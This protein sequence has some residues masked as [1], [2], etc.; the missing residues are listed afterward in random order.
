MFILETG[1]VNENNGDGGEG[2]LVISIMELV[3]TGLVA[4]RRG[5]MVAFGSIT[6]FDCQC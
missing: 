4:A 6:S 2:N 1:R 5:L 3:G